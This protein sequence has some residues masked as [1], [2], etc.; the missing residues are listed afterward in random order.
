M[1]KYK[2]YSA[3]SILSF[4]IGLVC[5]LLIGVFIIHE[6]GYE[7][8][9]PYI[10]STYRIVMSKSIGDITKSIASIPY[11]AAPFLKEDFKE[12]LA[13]YTLA[14]EMTRKTGIQYHVDHIVPLQGENISGL[15]V[16]WNLQVITGSENSRKGNKI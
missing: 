14:Q 1:L 7:S 3:I 4:A 11:A 9:N 15:H 6:T 12:I 10:N 8:G 5:T 16:P 13:F 2:T